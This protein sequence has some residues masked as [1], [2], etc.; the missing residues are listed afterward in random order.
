[1]LA[2]L[3]ACGGAGARPEAAPR[4]AAPPPLAVTIE[5]LAEEDDPRAAGAVAARV[6]ERRAGRH[7]RL[8][9]LEESGPV[10]PDAWPRVTVRNDTPHGLVVWF[11]GACPRT[12]AVAPRQAADLELCEGRYDVAAQLSSPD[13]LPFVGEGE[14][15]VDGKRYALTFYVVSQPRTTTRVRVRR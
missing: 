11:A 13:F 9:P 15:V 4:A 3:G 6:A 8:P 2:A 10:A 7:G 12:L 1:V 14:E 5:V